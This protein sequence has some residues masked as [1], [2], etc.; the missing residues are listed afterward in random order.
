MLDLR[1]VTLSRPSGGALATPL[2]LPENAPHVPGMITH[3]AL[4]LDEFG[5]PVE[6]PQAR[7]VPQ[8]F[9]PPLECALHPFELRRAESRLSACTPRMPEPAAAMLG[10]L[11]RPP[12][13][14]LAVHSEL[15]RH[16]SFRHAALQQLRGLQTTLLHRP[17]ITFHPGRMSHAR[18]YT[19]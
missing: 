5:H 15:T 1:L 18:Q 6:C 11:L 17:E 19:G 16:F 7:G 3:A 4:L 14:G 2:Q 8:S 9:G 13:D 10:Q 12:L